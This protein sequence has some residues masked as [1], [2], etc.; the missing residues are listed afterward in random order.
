MLK[1]FLDS[2][3]SITV[4]YC[5]LYISIDFVHTNMYIHR[6]HTL[7]WSFCFYHFNL[8]FATAALSCQCLFLYFSFPFVFIQPFTIWFQSHT[9]IFLS[10]ILWLL[11]YVGIH[12]CTLST[13]IPLS[14]TVSLCFYFSLASST[15]SWC[16]ITGFIF[17]YVISKREIRKGNWKRKLNKSIHIFISPT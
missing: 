4:N 12:I 8:V 17:V 9:K 16:S 1:V 15:S 2:F 10:F 5:K 6:K 7:K 11:L 14:F 3:I 13:A